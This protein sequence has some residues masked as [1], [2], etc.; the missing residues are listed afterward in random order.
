M[1]RRHVIYLHPVNPLDSFQ[2][3]PVLRQS[4]KWRIKEARIDIMKRSHQ[5]GLGREL[6]GKI[7][8]LEDDPFIRKRDLML[9]LLSLAL[10]AVLCVGFGCILVILNNQRGL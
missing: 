3:A 6:L 5:S 1:G 4:G 2:S 9:L 8:S 10:G 7:L